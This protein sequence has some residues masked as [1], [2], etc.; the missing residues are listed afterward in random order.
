MT[1]AAVAKYEDDFDDVDPWIASALKEIRP[2]SNMFWW[3]QNC[4]A[5]GNT[6]GFQHAGP[7]SPK[8]VV[9]VRNVCR[10]GAVNFAK[11]AGGS[12]YKMQDN[13][14]EL[15]AAIL[16]L[17]AEIGPPMTVRQMYYKL[18][19]RGVV[20]KTN[21][22]YN[23]VQNQ[24]TKMRRVGSI[25]YGWI[26]DNSRSYYQPTQY[27][28]LNDALSKMHQYY[29]RDLWDDQ[30]VHVEIW[31]EKRALVSQLKPICDEFG[32]R[33]YPCGGFTSIGFAAEAADE[34][35]YVDKP[36]YVYHL[37]DFDADGA[38]SSVHL[39]AEL[40]L[41]GIDFEFK[42]LALSQAQISEFGLFASLRPQ[43]RKSPRFNW[44]SE[45]FGR[46]AMACELDAIDPRDLRQL[47]HNTIAQHIDND[48]WKS[49][50]MIEA[51]ERKTLAHVLETYG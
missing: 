26:S 19:T 50:Q 34:L 32:V 16:D 23:R 17:F 28:G 33:L 9:L 47:V 15:Q 21:S 39:E 42:R 27:H 4:G 31:L 18:E 43:K 10:C 35:R 22:G 3:H 44:W 1:T 46:G 48:S 13:T 14:F 45:Q 12:A 29:R 11:L 41:H 2:R 7:Q 49:L 25:P 24:L 37:S 8:D 5:C 30:S 38:Y 36:I 40:R 20:D 6:I 51:E